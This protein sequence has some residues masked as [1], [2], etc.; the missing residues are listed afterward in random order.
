M[1]RLAI[2]I[3]ML[4]IPAAAMAQTDID[5]SVNY[6]LHIT[7]PSYSGCADAAFDYIDDGFCAGLN[8]TSS[9]GP[10]FLWVVISR[11]GG[12]GPGIGGA[13]FG[14][15]HAGLD[16]SGWALCTGGSEIPGDNWPDSGE[17]NAV[18]WGGGCYSPGGE[19]AMVGYFSLND[20]TAGNASVTADP[21]IAEAQWADCDATLAGVC[22]DN[23]AGTVLSDGTTP[24]CGDFCGGGTP[25]VSTTWGTIKSLY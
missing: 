2:A 24:I 3:T 12:F 13:Q 23:L 5:A 17:G 1:N 16:H 8:S 20:G 11:E 15:E 7:L 9:I 21:R 10:A 25:T 18:T 4:A 22:G 6:N 14:M 19:A